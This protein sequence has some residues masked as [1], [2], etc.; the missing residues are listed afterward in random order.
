MKV[1]QKY[2]FKKELK[3]EFLVGRSIQELK[4]EA[5]V[6]YV[7]LSNVLNGK[8]S[9]SLI[10]AK[11]LWQNADDFRPFEYYFKKE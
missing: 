6:S 11:N 10:Y 8:C 7:Y 4:I 2:L 5:G 3:D 9:C 1:P